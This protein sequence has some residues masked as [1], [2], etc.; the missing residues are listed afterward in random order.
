MNKLVDF[1]K[2]KDDYTWD[3][4]IH[5]PIP[6]LNYIMK[7]TGEDLL[8]DFDTKLEAEG[9]LVAITRTAKNYLFSNRVDLLAWEYTIAHDRQLLYEVLDYVLEFINFAFTTGDYKQLMEFKNDRSYSLALV[10]AKN[11]LLGAKKVIINPVNFRD[12]Y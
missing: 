3:K 12:G 9:K 1:E 8:L 4:I 11:N 2:D 6:T 5:F 10:N 7:R